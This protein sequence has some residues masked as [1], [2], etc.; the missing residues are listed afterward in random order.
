VV[1]TL[2]M[3][4]KEDHP[5]SNL[6]MI[7]RVD[8]RTTEDLSSSN[9]EETITITDL[10]KSTTDR[11]EITDL[12]LQDSAKTT[13]TRVDMVVALKEAGTKVVR[14]V[15]SEEHAEEMAETEVASKVAML[16]L[17]KTRRSL[18]TVDL[19][20]SSVLTTMVLVELVPK[21]ITIE[22]K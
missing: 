1:E 10:M 4:V 7:T 18:P 2:I 15:A 9:Q 12:A 19:S 17:G 20:K 22:T 14:E 11:Q 16:E 21:I 8:M 6:T 5:L 13:I 3:L